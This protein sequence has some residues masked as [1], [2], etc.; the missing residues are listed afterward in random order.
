MCDSDSP[1]DAVAYCVTCS[2][3]ICAFCESVHNRGVKQYR[4]HKLLPLDSEDL[5]SLCHTKT[6]LYCPVHEG[7][8]LDAY[9]I[10]CHCLVCV[11][12]VVERHQGD[13]Q[14]R[15]VEESTRQEVEGILNALVSQST[16]K[17]ELFRD[18][19][20][21]IQHVERVVSSRPEKYISAI[22]TAFDA[23]I[24]TLEACR[25]EAL[26]KAENIQERAQK[27]VWAQKE[28]V[29]RATTN[30][31]GVLSFSKRL[32]T[33]SS[34]AVLLGLASQAIA[35]LRELEV[36]Q[37]E[38]G[39][40]EDLEQ[41]CIQFTSNDI[42]PH[43]ETFGQV[44]LTQVKWKL[45]VE[46]EPANP[47]LGEKCILR[48]SVQAENCNEVIQSPGLKVNVQL[49]TG[50][51]KKQMCLEEPKR[52]PDGSWTVEH[53]L[54]CGGDNTFTVKAI[55][56]K[57]LSL[58]TIYTVNVTGMPPVGARV[59]R[60]PDWQYPELEPVQNFGIILKHIVPAYRLTYPRT[61]RRNYFSLQIQWGA[62]LYFRW[63][64]EG[65]Y[66]VQLANEPQASHS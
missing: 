61:Q 58:Q 60:G 63:G 23:Q 24:A 56:Q 31:Q 3:Y 1:T 20:R 30:M 8:K 36:I 66:D 37:W 55:R 16:E 41:S 52:H 43:L 29:E 25:A 57:G 13:H 35:R 21:Y 51:S 40:M 10:T 53:V 5:E 15:L 22:N 38:S 19:L 45:V 27:D 62:S 18:H 32:S 46:G 12:C 44:E 7:S 33:C 26:K 9:C 48:I 4:S 49:T 50:K 64:E 47:T 14:L 39:Q 34:N 59:V 2:A 42:K 28:Y 65:F 17:F 11:A 54:V 6:T